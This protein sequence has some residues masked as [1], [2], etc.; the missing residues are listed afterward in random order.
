MDLDC[1]GEGL[2]N[3][4]EEKRH[5]ASFSAMM[6]NRDNLVDHLVQLFSALCVLSLLRLFPQMGVD[7]EEL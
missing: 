3:P 4:I 2:K 7:F 1:R 5:A 6:A